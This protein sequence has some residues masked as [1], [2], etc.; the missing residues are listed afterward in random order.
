MKDSEEKLEYR[1][2]RKIKV[3]NL[4]K[5]VK[6]EHVGWDGRAQ[7]IQQ[8]IPIGL[9]ALRELLDSEVRQLVGVRYERGADYTRWGINPGWAYLGDQKV[10]IP[11][12]PCYNWT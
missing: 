11:F 8:L 12:E 10:K 2:R 6:T 3:T 7:L 1:E 9:L 5:E 4:A